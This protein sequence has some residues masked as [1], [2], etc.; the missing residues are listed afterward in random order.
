MLATIPNQVTVYDLHRN[1]AQRNYRQRESFERIL[2]QCY[3]RIKRMNRLRQT[4][5][6]YVIPQMLF[7]KPVFDMNTCAAFV[8]R[9]LMGNGFYVKCPPH[10]P[11]ILYISWDLKGPRPSAAHEAMAAAATSQGEMP[12]PVPPPS[13]AGG[14]LSRPGFSPM[15]PQ[16]HRR[17]PMMAAAAPSPLADRQS[18][19]MRHP[20]PVSIDAQTLRGD[21]TG[22]AYVDEQRVDGNDNKGTIRGKGRRSASPKRGGQVASPHSTAPVLDLPCPTRDGIFP[23]PT[24]FERSI[25]QFKPSGKFT[26]RL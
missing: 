6:T 8:M 3:S 9:N 24:L 20:F 4:S 12:V 13:A 17:S 1:T 22:S 15:S 23:P 7:G 14:S 21:V 25:A 26:L 2:E 10:S 18:A 11:N 5:C 19:F 16:R